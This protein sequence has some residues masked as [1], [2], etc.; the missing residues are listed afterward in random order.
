MST[1]QHET[2]ETS[3]VQADIPVPEQPALALHSSSAEEMESLPK[4]SIASTVIF[5]QE[6][7]EEEKEEKEEE[8]GQEKEVKS[9]LKTD[10]HVADDGYKAVWFKT[11][12]DP[13][14]GERVE[15]IE[16][17]AADD[18]DDDDGSDQDLQ[19]NEEEEEEV[20]DTDSH[21]R[22]LGVSFAS[23]SSSSPGEVTV[24]MSHTDAGADDSE[25]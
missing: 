23:E 16:D 1:K 18:D 2:S 19:K 24:N 6:E 8:A 10:R 4:G 3:S 11:D 12:V 21:H 15:V 14:A 9:I 13:E 20:S 7:K 17:N 22:G 5:D 25:L